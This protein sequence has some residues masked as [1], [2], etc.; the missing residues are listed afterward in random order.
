MYFVLLESSRCYSSLNSYVYI[1]ILFSQK[2]FL[3][4]KEDDEQAL[5][6][7]LTQITPLS[8]PT[9]RKCFPMLGLNLPFL[10]F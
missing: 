3:R 8:F 7:H 1:P 5:R 9:H 2:I 6:D 4:N 10:E